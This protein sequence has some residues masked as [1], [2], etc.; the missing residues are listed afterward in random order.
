MG[1]GEA[2][3]LWLKA[4]GAEDMDDKAAQKNTTCVTQTLGFLALAIVQADA[5]IGQGYCR[6]EEYCDLFNHC[7]PKLL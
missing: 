5:Y 4:Y 3:T 7:R 1:L 2:A 6:I